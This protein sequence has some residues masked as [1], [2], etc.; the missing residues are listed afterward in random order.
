MLKSPSPSHN[1][2]VL[3]KSLEALSM[4]L[5]EFTSLH[6]ELSREQLAEI[7]GCKIA[8]VQNWFAT[9]ATH[10]EP[11]DHHKMRFAIAHYLSQEPAFYRSIRAVLDSI[12][13]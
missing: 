4:S 12:S 2:K 9:G 13:N 6:P 10:R 8:T 7:A 11:T 1:W 5:E 3:A